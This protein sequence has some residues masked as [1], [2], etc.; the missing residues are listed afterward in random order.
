MILLVA[1]LL[2]AYKEV[3]AAKIN[4][5]PNWTLLPVGYR[6]PVCGRSARR[7]LHDQPGRCTCGS[8]AEHVDR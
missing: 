6:E 1:P 4:L 8:C 5:I 3:T 2:L 7:T